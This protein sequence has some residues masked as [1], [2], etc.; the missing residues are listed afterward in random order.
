MSIHA[1]ILLSGEVAE[2]SGEHARINPY[3]YGATALVVLLALL[4]V[5]T[6]LKVDR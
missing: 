3:V 2:E 1:L 4:F 6:R 5:V